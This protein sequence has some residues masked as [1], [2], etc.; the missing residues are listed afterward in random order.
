MNE[1]VTLRKEE[2]VT[3]SLMV[4]EMF[5][6]SHQHVLRDI[7]NLDC[8]IEFRKS[9]F[10]RSSYQSEQNKRFPMYF[11]TKD[12]FIFLAMGYRGKKAAEFKEAYI[13]AFNKM[14][15]ILR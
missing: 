15:A 6:K 3:T 1:L 7:E 2:A 9:N 14:E 10:G 8:S 5:H 11:I 4:A 13:S 12:G